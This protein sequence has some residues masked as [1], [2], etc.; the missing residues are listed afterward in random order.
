M[1]SHQPQ[2]HR[3][4]SGVSGSEMLLKK[5][6]SQNNLFGQP[7]ILIFVLAQNINLCVP[8]GKMIKLHHGWEFSQK[9]SDIIEMEND[10]NIDSSGKL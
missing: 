9:D 1:S 7:K 6:L 5:K 3:Y 10:I 2:C 8:F 4:I